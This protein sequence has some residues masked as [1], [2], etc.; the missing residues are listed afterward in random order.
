LVVSVVVSV[1]FSVAV[2]PAEGVV[3][4]VFVSFVVV[5][6]AVLPS[7]LCV[8]VVTVLFSVV[9]FWLSQPMVNTPSAEIR[10][11]AR[12]LF[13]SI[14]FVISGDLP[15]ASRNRSCQRFFPLGY[16][17][18]SSPET[19]KADVAEHPKAFDHVGLL[20]NEPPG[21]TGLLSI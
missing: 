16:D 7:L 14:P 10:T 4:F 9:P 6:L 5:S 20:V 1:V 11:N 21:R 2:P 8:V 17:C 18:L 13:I 19:K 3:V 15:L 12:K